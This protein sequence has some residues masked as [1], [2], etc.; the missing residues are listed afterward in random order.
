MQAAAGFQSKFL[1]APVCR[2]VNGSLQVFDACP[3]CSQASEGCRKE[4][5]TLC[6]LSGVDG[7]PVHA[8]VLS[9][10]AR[11]RGIF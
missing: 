10:N 8:N 11:P 4:A 6:F 2:S 3:H 5:V 1:T 9:T 7:I